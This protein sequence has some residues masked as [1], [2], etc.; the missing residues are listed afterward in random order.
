MFLGEGNHMRAERS[1]REFVGGAVATGAVIGGIALF[2]QGGDQG[3]APDAGVRVVS[4]RTAMPTFAVDP[5]EV[6]RWTALVGRPVA[7]AGERGPVGGV[8]ESV[9]RYPSG[10]KR[11]ADV[12]RENFVVTFVVDRVGAPAGDAIYEIGH[13]V[14]GLTRLFLVRGGDRGAKTVLFAY[15]N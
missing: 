3:L 9:L 2:G 8:I 11:P 13:A 15:F 5:V 1:R 4:G 14:D 10:G 7:I 6:E 12:R